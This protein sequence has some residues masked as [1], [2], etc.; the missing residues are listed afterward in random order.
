MLWEAVRHFLVK[1]CSFRNPTTEY[2][3]MIFISSRL[4][5]NRVIS[6]LSFLRK[7]SEYLSDLSIMFYMN[8]SYNDTKGW[9]VH[10]LTKIFPWNATKLGLFFNII[11]LTI[12]ILLLTVFQCLNH[13]AKKINSRYDVIIWTFLPTLIQNQDCFSV[14]YKLW[15][16]KMI[17]RS[18]SGLLERWRGNF[19]VV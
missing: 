4:E 11:P 5:G 6:I 1:I 9:K 19:G 12:N 15:I 17:G 7:I 13:I 18:V 2:S 8:L 16:W 3:E 10:R 14:W